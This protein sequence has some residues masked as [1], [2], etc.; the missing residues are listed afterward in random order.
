MLYVAA[1]AERLLPARIMSVLTKL[2]GLVLASLAAELVF[3]GIRGF[4]GH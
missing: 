3:T 1:R 2:T 4:L